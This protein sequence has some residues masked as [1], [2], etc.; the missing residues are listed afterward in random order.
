[1]PARS[2][3]VLSAAFAT[4]ACSQ[5][6]SAQEGPDYAREAEA[7]A[8]LAETEA[9]RAWLGEAAHLPEVPQRTVHISFRPKRA[10]TAAQYEALPESEREGLREKVCN[11]ES[12]YYDT[13]YGTPLA[14]LR[15]LDL[16]AAH[17]G[18]D[19]P[20]EWEGVRILDFGYGQMGQLRMLAQRGAHAVGV[21]I[22]PILAAIY[23]EPGDTGPVERDGGKDGSVTLHH[24]AWPNE[25]EMVEAVEEAGGDGYDLIVSRNLLKRGYV[26]PI[27]GSD[28]MVDL[29]GTASETLAR[30][31]DTLAPGGVFVIYNIGGEPD[32]SRPWTDIACPWPAELL[33]DAGF[34]VLAYDVNEDAPARAVGRALG[35]DLGERPM[36]LTQ[37]FGTY[38][39]LRRPAD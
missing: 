24:G 33:K 4:L 1:M 18:G 12:G 37:L 26:A 7:L 16:A 10:Y 8:E 17:M 36:D 23:S 39:I 11:A 27:D 15:A 13:F 31:H 25:P 19:E 6:A 38:T 21:D 3:L 9:A 34:E 30:F 28:A 2:M 32:P 20:F 5:A 35:W 29:G 14:Y 22:D